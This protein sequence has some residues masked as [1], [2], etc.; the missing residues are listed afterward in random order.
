VGL[1][2]SLPT[3]QRR[4]QF[5]TKSIGFHYFFTRKVMLSAAAQAYVF[6]PGGFG[7]IDEMSE[8]VTLVQT[9]KIPRNVPI[10]LFGKAFWQP[11]LD[12][13]KNAMYDD[14]RYISKDDLML[15]HLVD[16]PEEAMKII[17]KTRERPYGSEQKTI[18]ETSRK[19]KRRDL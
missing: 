6:F 18:L 3:E 19:P 13:V 12:W 11:L 9:G 17:R 7:T 14:R 5:V 10:I 4:N 16:T 15:M 2:I 1:D 8:M